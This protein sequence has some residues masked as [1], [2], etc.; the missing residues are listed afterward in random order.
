[1]AL[2]SRKKPVPEPVVEPVV[3]DVP[4]PRRTPDE[5]L[6]RL[7]GGVDALRPFG[8]QINDVTGLTLCEE[9]VS[10]LDLPLVST[11]RTAGYGVRAANLV[12]ATPDH[13]IDLHVVGV[14]DRRDT[15][16]A[17]AVASG[18]CVVLS[19]GAPVPAGVDAVVPASEA[20][21]TGRVARFVGEAAVGQ[22][23]AVRGSELAEGAKLMSPGRILD[24][25]S[26]ALLAEIGLD[27]V[28]VRPKPRLVVFAVG[29]GLVSPG[30]P[31]T[32]I[33][34]RYASGTSYVTAAARGDGA[35]VYQLDVVGREAAVIRQTIADQ[36][37]RADA[38]VV[39]AEDDTDAH[40]VAGLLADIGTVD[41]AHVLVDGGQTLAVGRVGDERIPALVLPAGAV[42]SCVGYHLFVRPLLDRLGA[43]ATS[44]ATL[45]GVL[46]TDLTADA[47]GV[48]YLPARL[49]GERVRPVSSGNDHAYDLFRADVLVRLP[50]GAELPAG[51]SVECIVLQPDADALP[52]RGAAA[53]AS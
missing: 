42:R 5:Q 31:I 51:S 19:E 40:L 27:K 26:I 24:A 48:R 10:D 13:P 29:E 8:M 23:L 1:M 53:T 39:L 37:I 15:M 44:A 34:Q 25:R 28:L 32:S 22:H 3:D 17:E 41:V 11:A 38:I 14:I 36:V 7:L 35:T 18:A 9:I 45:R 2:F 12:G 6:A 46:A 52:G 49:E 43:R 33:A 21:S 30:L 16:P 47:D 50:A 20:T 4:L